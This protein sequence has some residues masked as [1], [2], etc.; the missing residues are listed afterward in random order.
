M[1]R[2]IAGLL[3]LAMMTSTTTFA[4]TR[5]CPEIEQTLADMNE[6]LTNTWMSPEHIDKVASYNNNKNL[7]AEVQRVHGILSAQYNFMLYAAK[8]SDEKGLAAIF[9]DMIPVADKMAKILL[10]QSNKIGVSEKEASMIR[11][12]VYNL[13]N[14]VL[15]AGVDRGC[16]ERNKL[17]LY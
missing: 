10:K 2:K 17:G 12:D 8:K 3:T 4:G 11:A 13:D 1:K 14:L 5:D 6:Y 16:I 15:R 7:K 9:G